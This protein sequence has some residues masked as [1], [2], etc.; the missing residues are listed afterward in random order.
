MSN[1]SNPSNPNNHLA[2]AG[3]ERAPMAGAREIGPANPEEVVEVT[4]R[5]RSRQGKQ[6]AVSAEEFRKPV[7]SRKLLTR[8]EFTQAHGAEQ[9]HMARVEK[10]AQDHHLKVIE[11]SAARRTVIVSG[12]VTE[13]N[14]AFGVELEK[15]QHATGEYRG[16]TGK[17]H[18]PAELHDVIEGVFGLDNRPQ[19]KPHFR[20]LHGRGGARAAAVNLSYTPV[21]VASLYDY[22]AGVD[23]TGETIGIIELGGGFEAA[24]LSAYWSQLNLAK[25]PTVTALGVGR[26]RNRPTGDPNGPDGEV[27]LD[28]EVCGATA[29][30][31][32]IVVYFAANTDA[33]FLTSPA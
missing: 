13:V 5:L 7:R 25:I 2:V 8:E 23:G 30:G 26:G 28:I 1:P 21:E 31:A 22:P 32:N 12:T 27:M 6:P 11:T 14:R 18:V 3:S 9:G 10:F 16:R 33:G 20:R 15:Y 17:I 19:A 4:I 29:P 24:D